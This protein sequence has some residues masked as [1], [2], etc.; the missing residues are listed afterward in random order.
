MNY[1]RDSNQPEKGIPNSLS[2]KQGL[3]IVENF[4]I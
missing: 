4:G 1:D 3:F 2:E